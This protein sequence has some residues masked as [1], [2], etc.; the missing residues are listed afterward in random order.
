MLQFRGQARQR[1]AGDQH[2][3]ELRQ[4]RHRGPRAGARGGLLARAH[5]PRPGEPR[6]DHQGQHPAR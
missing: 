4:V 5:A 3:Q 1:A 2:R 6:G